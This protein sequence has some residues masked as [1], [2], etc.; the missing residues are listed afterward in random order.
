MIVYF[1]ATGNSHYCADRL[2][3]LLSEEV[4]DAFPL[5]RAGKASLHS[6]HPWV[7]VAPT[8]SWQLPRFFATFLQEA[9]LSGNKDAYFVLT[10]GSEIGNADKGLSTLCQQIGLTYRGVFPI[11][12]PDNYI[13]LFRPPTAEE[14]K[15][16]VHAAQPTLEQCAAAIKA[17]QDFPPRRIHVMDRL[18]SGPV[19]AGFY[20]FFIKASRFYATDQCIGCGKC[21]NVCVLNNIHLVDGKP[22]WGNHCTHCMACI[23]LC[24]QKA[25]EYGHSTQKKGRYQCPIPSESHEE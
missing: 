8:Y 22:V 14:S 15:E 19:N 6:D 11:V 20:R 24:P 21:A 10:C 23:C 9:Q 16:I 5:I 17:G 18:K 12:M 7:F 2:G 1:S 3:T 25:I 13:V 4:V